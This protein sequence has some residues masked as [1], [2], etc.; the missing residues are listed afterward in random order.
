MRRV[1]RGLCCVLVWAGSLAAGCSNAETP[2]VTPATVTLRVA[3]ESALYP[4]MQELTRAYSLEQPHVLFTLSSN[5][6]PAAAEAIYNQRADIAAVSVLPVTIAGRNPPWL[7]DLATDGIAVIVNPANPLNGLSTQQLRDLYA[8]AYSRWDELGATSIGDIQLAVRESDDGTRI[9][10]DRLVMGNTRLSLNA[11]VLPSVEIMMNFVAYQPG[12][13]GYVPSTRITETVSPPVKTLSIDGQFP[14]FDALTGGAYPLARPLYLIASS[15]PQGELR[16]FA[17][18][19]L[20]PAG[21]RI[22]HAAQYAT[23]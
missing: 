7:A 12:A 1:I 2:R 20:G 21:R 23:P 9:L 4:L 16:E 15:E 13:I 5:S 10:F 14:T 8:G 6:T 19:V 22:I 11:V 17:A 18:W 3:A